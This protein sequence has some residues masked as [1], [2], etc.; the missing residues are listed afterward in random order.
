MVILNNFLKGAENPCDETVPSGRISPKTVR[1]RLVEQSA[2]V[3]HNITTSLII[4]GR[5]YHLKG[6]MT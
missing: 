3:R 5:M 2:S 1:E 4:T 6:S